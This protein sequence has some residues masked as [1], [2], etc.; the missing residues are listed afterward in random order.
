[1][2][3]P[4]E[5]P[6]IAPEATVGA[7]PGERWGHSKD[8][9]ERDKRR[10]QSPFPRQLKANSQRPELRGHRLKATAKYKPN[11]ALPQRVQCKTQH[12]AGAETGKKDQEKEDNFAQFIF[13]DCPQASFLNLFKNTVIRAHLYSRH[14][15]S[16]MN[17]TTAREFRNIS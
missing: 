13:R 11:A 8:K 5:D 12:R 16:H 2:S 6:R 4:S 14:A 10:E 3:C 9:V 1:M 17:A 15:M 7:S